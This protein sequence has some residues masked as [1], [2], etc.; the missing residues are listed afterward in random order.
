MYEFA[1]LSLGAYKRG[2]ETS[3]PQTVSK[4]MLMG[5]VHSRDISHK[6][7]VLHASCR[8]ELSNLFRYACLVC[9]RVMECFCH[10]IQTPGTVAGKEEPVRRCRSHLS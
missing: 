10:C 1:C 6:L 4:P 2:T 7:H 5:F 3:A 8:L 9:G